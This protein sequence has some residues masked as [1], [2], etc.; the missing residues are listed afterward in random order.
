MVR[1]RVQL[2]AGGGAPG[3]VARACGAAELLATDGDQSLLPLLRANCD[4]NEGSGSWVVSVLDWRDTHAVG[5]TRAADG[6]R[7]ELVLLADVLYTAGD[8]APLVRAACALLRPG[9]CSRVLLARSSW[10][11]D[12]QPSLV[13]SA[14][15][16]GLELLSATEMS[17]D[18]GNE[19]CAHAPDGLD[20]LRGHD[21]DG[22]ACV[23]EFAWARSAKCE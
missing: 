20:A 23:L 6:G 1:P 8:I 15:E 10:F 18:T 11:E 21:Y 14:D 19:G 12:L 16:H 5:T 4:A 2:G 13:A 22:T 17:G 3:L 9:G 7:F